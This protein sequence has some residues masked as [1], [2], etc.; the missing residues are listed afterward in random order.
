MIRFTRPGIG[1]MLAVALAACGA[2]DAGP[3]VAPAAAPIGA[4]AVATLP[5][6]PPFTGGADIAGGSAVTMTD[7]LTVTNP[8]V[9]GAS[10]PLVAGEPVSA[11]DPLSPSGGA[12][13]AEAMQVPWLWQGT[14]RSDGTK[15]T[16][17]D[18][19]AYSLLFVAE[20]MLAVRADC[21]GGRYAYSTDG[22]GLTIRIAGPKGAA[23]PPPS[24]AEA[25]LADLVAVERF[26]LNGGS[27]VLDLASGAGSMVFARGDGPE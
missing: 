16:P 25:F 7:G 3:A 19:S 12:L 14:A 15:Q 20:G 24:H 4:S 8:M 1:L 5:P 17:D 13:P 6:A 11:T 22:V 27:L 10:S 2:P 23:C 21:G 26:T 9:D 18:P